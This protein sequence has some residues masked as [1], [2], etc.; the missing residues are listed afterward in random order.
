M[1]GHTNGVAR[2]RSHRKTKVIATIG[3]S[4]DS[5]E[6]IRAMIL[7]GMNVA[8]LNFSHGTHEEHRKWIQVI[9]Q[10]CEE[11]S[12]NVAIMLDTK[13]VKIRT[14]RFARGEAVLTTGGNFD[15]YEHDRLGDASGVSISYAGLAQE[16]TTG[17]AILLDDGVIELRVDSV[18]PG[19]I[20]TK[21]T[22]GG[23][24]KDRKGVNLPGASLPHGAMT[25][26]DR[27]DL[28]FA[29]DI[30]LRRTI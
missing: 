2:K 16:V 15:L 26:E 25:A 18:E 28:L 4:C 22:R 27:D 1:S 20:H 11:E 21:I 23:L 30:E 17:C 8:R 12:A 29:I 13:G 24:I 9:R 5:L 19:V 10:A 14:G 3:P 7:A 6:T